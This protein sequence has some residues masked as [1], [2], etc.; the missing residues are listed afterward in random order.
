[1][2]QKDNA[3]QLPATK[4]ARLNTLGL[5]DLPDEMMLE[6]IKRVSFRDLITLDFVCKKLS[7]LSRDSLLWP[8]N[9]TSDVIDSNLRHQI[10]GREPFWQD[11]E[12]HPNIK[13]IFLSLQKGD[14]SELQQI[15]PDAETLV[16]AFSNVTK[17]ILTG[18][19]RM[20]FDC[21]PPTDP[22]NLACSNYLINLIQSYDKTIGDNE[23]GLQH[24]P[25]SVQLAEEFNRGKPAKYAKA[26]LEILF[27]KYLSQ[28]QDY[29]SNYRALRGNDDFLFSVGCMVGHY[30]ILDHYL[31]PKDE[32]LATSKLHA[33]SIP[34]IE[35]YLLSMSYND[36]KLKA[37]FERLF[38]KQ[39]MTNGFKIIVFKLFKGWINIFNPYNFLINY[40]AVRRFVLNSP[41]KH[42]LFR[43]KL[44]EIEN[45]KLIKGIIRQ[46][47][48]RDDSVMMQRLYALYAT[49]ITLP[50]LSG[51][52]NTNKLLS[53][54]YAA[55]K[56]SIAVIQ[57]LLDRQFD[58]NNQ[59]LKCTT[60]LQQAV[61][62]GRLEVVKFLLEK[63]AR[64]DLGFIISAK[65]QLF[66][67][68]PLT[69]SLRCKHPEITNYLYEKG[70][71]AIGLSRYDV[72][73]AKSFIPLQNDLSAQ[74][75]QHI[76]EFLTAHNV[77]IS[78]QCPPQ[79]EQVLES[80]TT[81]TTP[82]N[83]DSNENQLRSPNSTAY[84]LSYAA[85]SFSSA[86]NPRK[87]TAE[88]M[89]QGGELVSENIIKKS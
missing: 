6:I 61:V 82:M 65:G 1:M 36:V 59:D 80:K 70:A 45:I 85:S 35:A 53:L 86:I 22:D 7:N 67:V 68:S 72:L 28:I 43:K 20:L 24:I 60:A 44:S 81:E 38:N 56:G 47:I 55:R 69:V 3:G 31:P 25:V 88:D 58:I 39:L 40:S 62:S 10:V 89:E 33:Y 50:V 14:L 16:Q 71:R 63:N 46:A 66:Q 54:Q 74:C 32:Y 19:R 27:A 37:K 49:R 4:R 79:L 83:V 75:K 41:I 23:L 48:G 76:V 2:Q 87:R 8:R 18:F 15:V 84:P 73:F 26:L 52:E 64:L 42:E 5:L 34:L 17:I 21:E 29:P 51:S 57:F 30:E 77:Q 11:L 13:A 12:T 78:H 9:S